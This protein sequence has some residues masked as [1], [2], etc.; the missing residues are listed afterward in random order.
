MCF[1]PTAS[2]AVGA[3]VGTLGAA[4]MM[5]VKRGEDRPLAAVP[6]VLG[7]QQMVEGLVWLSFGAPAFNAIATY[8]YVAISYLLWPV[9]VPLAV[10]RAEP[11]A[12]RRRLVRLCAMAGASVVLYLLPF[13][14]TA[15]VSSRVVGHSIRYEIAGVGFPIP[16]FVLY[17][18][19]IFGSCM[20]STPRALRLLGGM[21][22]LG[23]AAASFA[24]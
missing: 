20:L 8:G 5:T 3:S 1:S 9:Y 6:L 2:L 19:S 10:Q 15:S 21:L 14:L 16:F 24:Q 12:G 22:L 11:D 17:V 4:A 13:V 18:T 23:P 7:V